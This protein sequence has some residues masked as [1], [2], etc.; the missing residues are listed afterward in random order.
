M[1]A[2]LLRLHKALLTPSILCV[3][4]IRT[5]SINWPAERAA[6]LPLCWARHQRQ[7]P[8]GGHPLSEAVPR[9]TDQAARR[10]GQGQAG[11]SCKGLSLYAGSCNGFGEAKQ[12]CEQ[13]SHWRGLGWSNR[14]T[15]W[16]H[17]VAHQ[18]AGH[19]LCNSLTRGSLGHCMP[20]LSPDIPASHWHPPK[21][22]QGFDTCIR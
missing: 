1:D 3:K 16:S 18:L 7:Y 21:R 20:C 15:T 11:G 10:A 22:Q 4:L 9:G 8:H 14:L 19:H 2:H 17:S 13:G 5:S 6:H 12:R